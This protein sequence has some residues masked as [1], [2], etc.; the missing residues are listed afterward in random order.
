MGRAMP[1]QRHSI[2]LLYNIEQIINPSRLTKSLP[3][4][5]NSTT[6][7]LE[8]VELAPFAGVDFQGNGRHLGERNLQGIM[9][10][11][12]VADEAVHFLFM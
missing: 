9:R 2:D 10:I 1:S 3:G 8:L 12:R 11:Q 7:I 4:L 5:D 6:N